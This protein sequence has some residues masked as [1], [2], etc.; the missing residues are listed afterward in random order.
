M[1]S[2]A[3]L[4]QAYYEK[5]YERIERNKDCLLAVMEETLREELLKLGFEHF[6]T[7][8]HAAYSEAAQAFL[9]ERLEAYN[10]IGIRHTFDTSDSELAAALE[11]QLNWYDATEEWEQ[12]QETARFLAQEDM[13][14]TS[15]IEQADLL[16]GRCGAWP[17]RSIIAAYEKTP[18]LQKLPDYVVALAIESILNRG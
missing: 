18:D 13:S 7:D 2:K 14:D 1:N 10:P 12:L 3:L 5:L 15:L 4:L 11:L 8:R 17:D 16:I 6:G 9:E